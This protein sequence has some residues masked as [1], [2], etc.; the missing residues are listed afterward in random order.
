MISRIRVRL[1]GIR[2]GVFLCRKGRPPMTSH[3][4]TS[5]LPPPKDDLPPPM[6]A[7]GERENVE[8]DASRAC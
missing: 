3:G 5:G 1:G 6:D 7:D 4:L 2:I 8:R